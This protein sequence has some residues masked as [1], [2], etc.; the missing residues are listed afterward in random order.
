MGEQICTMAFRFIS[1]HILSF[2]LEALA[3][4][5]FPGVK[6]CPKLSP[7]DG[8]KELP[9]RQEK[10][11]YGDEFSSSERSFQ[12][13]KQVKIR[14]S[15]IREVRWMANWPYSEFLQTLARCPRAVETGV[16]HVQ[17]QVSRRLC[18]IK[19]HSFDNFSNDVVTEISL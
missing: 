7:S 5:P 4:S 11:V 3:Q 8:P 2:H 10:F 15:Q 1:A 13:P 9:D 19:G 17:H 12:L 18:Q 6:N 14:G 16:I